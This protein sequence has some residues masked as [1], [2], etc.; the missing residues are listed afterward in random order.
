MSHD[1]CSTALTRS[2]SAAH[3]GHMPGLPGPDGRHDDLDADELEGLALLV[4]DDPRSLDGDRDTYL[5]ELR[6]K[7][8]AD[9]RGS[10][11]LR[12]LVSRSTSGMR[13]GIGLTGPLLLVLLV[14]VGL[15]GSSLSVFGT[16][17]PD[18]RAQTPLATPGPDQPAGSVGGLLPD[19]ML[20]GQ[21]SV[22]PLRKARPA[23][24]I[25]VPT[26][27]PD[28]GDIL[29]SLR[30]QSAGYSLPMLLVGPADQLQQLRSARRRR[31]RRQ[32][33][34]GDRHHRR[35]RAGRT[36]RPGSPRS[37]SATTA[38][39]RWSRATSRP[40]PGWRATWSSWT[41]APRRPPDPGGGHPRGG[42]RQGRAPR[43]VRGRHGRR[44]RAGRHGRRAG[45][46]CVLLAAALLTGQ[47]SIGWCNDA[48]DRGRDVAAGRTDKPLAVGTLGVRTVWT[49][50]VA[51]R[52]RVRAALAR[53]RSR[54]RGDPPRGRGRRV[55]VRPRAQADG[56]LV[57][58]VRRELRAA[59]V[60]GDAG[61]AD[62]GDAAVVGDH[63]R[64]P[65][66]RGRPPRQ[67]PARP[68]GRRGGRCPRP[69]AA[70]RPGP[71][72]GDRGRAPAGRRGCCSR[73]PRPGP[74]GLAGAG[75]LVV[76][77]VALVA[78]FAVDWPER[79]RTPFVLIVLAALAVVGLLLVHGTTLA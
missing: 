65:A 29:R 19:V 57:R 46:T 6:A 15:V 54:R 4:P 23:V 10:G 38:S 28:C 61:A 32:R 40:A 30:L 60:G 77:V 35:A 43:P 36:C 39:S 70:D 5:R 72:Q 34:G 26:S 31:A 37:W 27:C 11:V 55:G 21:E 73:S 22:F 79:S 53:A 75:L 59:P 8:D 17:S 20:T 66:R 78:A 63:G 24:L 44:D 3:T 1:R 50:C 74:V 14:V 69:A 58:A 52:R 33:R 13:P 47:L 2:S 25:M 62:T 12:S 9:R 64:G 18:D 51:G 49:A 16:S 76:A 45:R 48:V 68:R 71:T 7:R 42:A 41:R 56:G 67:R